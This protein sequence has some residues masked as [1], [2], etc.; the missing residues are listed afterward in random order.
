MSMPVLALEFDTSLDDEVRKNYN[1]SK[2]EEDMALPAL[3]KILEEKNTEVK[4]KSQPSQNTA[5]LA[6]ATFSKNEQKP[7]AQTSQSPTYERNLSYKEGRRSSNE[8]FAVIKKGTRIRV[9]L[10]TEISDRTKKGT[11]VTFV[12]EYPVSTRYYTI[13]SGTV[14]KGEVV[15]SHKPQLTGNGGLISIKVNSVLLNNEVQ[16]IDAYVARANHKNI[17][18][19]KI[20]GRRKYV[21]SMFNSMRPGGRFL[22]K[23]VGV[24]GRLAVDGSSILLTPFSLTLGVLGFGGNVLVSPVMATFYKGNS[25]NLDEN[26]EFV[27][28]LAEDVFIYK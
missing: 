17:F 18:F 11:R 28:K 19:N 23:M 13:R 16:P 2:I 12:S 3:P 27:L 5:P 25:L 9:R 6:K 22:K 4:V 1:P 10:K 21:A 7:T 20:K 8:D 26:T 15:A 14:F 24:T